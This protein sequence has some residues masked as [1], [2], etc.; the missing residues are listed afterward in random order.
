MTIATHSAPKT[1]DDVPTAPKP[2]KPT[3]PTAFPTTSSPA[4][5]V[6]RWCSPPRSPSP[7]GTV[8]RC[9]IAG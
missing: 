5:P 3:P 7:T 6:C 4:S 9:A 8:V 2:E 1:T